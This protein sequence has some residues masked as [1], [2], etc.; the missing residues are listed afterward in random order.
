MKLGLPQGMRTIDLFVIG[1]AASVGF[2]VS[3]F[4]ATVALPPG[5]VQDA[6]KMGA[7][8]SFGAAI[9]AVIAGIVTRV[10]K[11]SH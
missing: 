5:D 11:V 3:L 8:F 6:A 1:C 10:Q 9:V 2:T 7:L 4:I